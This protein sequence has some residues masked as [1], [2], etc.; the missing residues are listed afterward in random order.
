MSKGGPAHPQIGSVVIDSTQVQHGGAERRYVYYNFAFL[1]ILFSRHHY[2]C[3]LSFLPY[4]PL[5]TQFNHFQD[6]QRCG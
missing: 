5:E 2:H 3:L 4:N 6:H 1:I